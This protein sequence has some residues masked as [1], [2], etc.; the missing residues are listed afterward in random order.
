MVRPPAEPR[1][2]GLANALGGVAIVGA[3]AASAPARAEPQGTVGLTIGAAGEGYDHEIWKRRTA[4]HLG[5]H[6]DIL[7]GRNSTGD[8]G[9]GPY[10]EAMTQSFDELQVGG[11]V[12]GLLP[13]PGLDGLPVVISAGGYARVASAAPVAASS[14]TV[15]VV[16]PGVSGQLFWGVRGYNFHSKYMMSGGVIAQM[17]YGLGPSRETAIILGAQIDVVLLAMPVLFLVTAARG[18]S[19]E[20][21]PSSH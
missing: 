9:I 19:R 16:Q 1:T 15:P 18:P 2:R 5:L 13:I 11:G 14:A 17:R 21:T 4:F 6:G 12:S 20:A 10:A 8:F 7:F 3:L